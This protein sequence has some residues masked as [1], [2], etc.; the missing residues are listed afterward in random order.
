[1]IRFALTPVEKVQPWNGDLHWFA[2]SSGTYSIDLGTHRLFEYADGLPVDYFLARLHEDL[3]QRLPEIL[4]PIPAEL[5]ER[6]LEG[7]A[8]VTWHALSETTEDLDD[9]VFDALEGFRVRALD[10]LYLT[11]RAHILQW[12]RGDEIIVEWDHR[13]FETCP[14]SATGLGRVAIPVE[15][16][17]AG[18]RR[19][20]EELMAQMAG[21]VRVATIPRGE[22][23]RRREGELARVLARP[24]AAYDWNVLLPLL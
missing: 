9:P 4:D 13:G 24:A 16:Y 5:A 15:R 11:P 1:M 7:S 6:F 17:L 20:H 3:L 2:L 14:W 23:Q 18:L 10:S 12:R 21:R 19:F 8:L 22:E